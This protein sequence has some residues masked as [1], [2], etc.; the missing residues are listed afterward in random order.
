[1]HVSQQDKNIFSIL[2]SHL[3]HY[4]C[5]LTSMYTRHGL[6]ATMYLVTLHPL[7]ISHCM[8]LYTLQTQPTCVSHHLTR[9]Q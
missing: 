7:A 2:T 9:L 3:S 5:N 8:Y 4:K 6:A 1:M